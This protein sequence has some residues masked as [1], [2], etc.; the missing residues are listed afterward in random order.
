VL[1]QTKNSKHKS[2]MAQTVETIVEINNKKIDKFSSLK[3]TQ[4]IYEHH[5]FRLVCSIDEVNKNGIFNEPANYIGVPLQ[6]QV[7]SPRDQSVLFFSGL[8]TKVEASC[9]YGEP[10]KII[11]SGFSPTILLEDGLHI[12]SWMRNSVKSIV[13]EISKQFPSDCLKYDINPDYDETIH[14][15][16]RYKETAWQFINR[17]AATYGEWLFYDGEKLVVGNS[18]GRTVHLNY[19]I[20]LSRFSREM[21]LKSNSEA[22]AAYD[23]IHNEVYNS[24][25]ENIAD[26]A[27]HTDLGA[28]V[29]KKSAKLFQV[30]SI[31]WFENM[32]R[33]KRQL[34]N[35]ARILAIKQ[36]SD[37]VRIHGSSDT[38]GFQ[39]GDTIVVKAFSIEGK[40][41]QSSGD[42]RI[43]SIDHCWDGTG[44]YSNEFVAIPATVKM[45]PIGSFPKPYCEK[46]N[47]VVVNNHDVDKLGR[48]Q[49][50]FLWMDEKQECPWLRVI[51]QYAG[52]S[53]GLYMM[54][55][56]G[57]EVI[58]DFVGGDATQPYV[59]GTVHNGKATTQFGSAQNDIKAIQTRSG[60]KVIMNDKEGS[61][62]LED[63]N[64]NGVQMD[65]DGTVTMKSKDKIMLACGESKIILNKEGTIE[66]TGRT[67]KVNGTEEVKIVSSDLA[68]INAKTLVEVNSATIKLN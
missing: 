44:N 15:T 23:Y 4:G 32:V 61:L 27:G 67:I 40:V 14:Y 51:T 38:P 48:I 55:E 28:S 68:N 9:N 43:I 49:V 63:K 47:A 31:C 57:E 50:R 41:D 33:K 11:F 22:W 46:Q 1:I 16:V 35:V 64:G 21:T 39:P 12:K 7:E 66:I 17:L 24:R 29:L 13:T 45:P 8:V 62:S 36:V 37:V 58:V 65:G 18:G 19:G 56:V 26:R 54:P 59:T 25:I 42:Y 53:K 5:S 52:N 6:I 30:K 60:I 34:D 3:L 20:Q 2:F 10:E